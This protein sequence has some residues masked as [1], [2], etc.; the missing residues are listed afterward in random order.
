MSLKA[1]NNKRIAKNT[2]M[3]YIRMGLVMIISLYATRIVLNVLG[4]ED[5]GIYNVVGGV[6]VMFSFLSRTLASA[7]QRYFAFEIGRGDYD[8]LNK[9]FNINLIL[10]A[11]VIGIVLIL[12]E[13]VGL[14]FVN[15]QMTIPDERMFAARWVYQFA[16]L[17][18]CAHLIAIP[19]Q[20]TIIA[21][22]RMDVYAFVG[23]LEA[24]LNLGFVFLLQ[25]LKA[26]Q[27]ALILYGALMLLVHIITNGSYVVVAKKKYEETRTKLY[28]ESQLVKEIISYSGWNLF[29]AV[30]AITRSQG[31]NL[32]I[33]V[34]F[35]PAINAARGLSYQVNNALNQFA[36]N[37]YTAVK[38]QVT[39]YYAQGDKSS[40][41]SL[42]FSSSKFAY[43]LLLFL[44]V[45]VLIYPYEVLE[46]WLVNVPQYAPLFLVLVVIIGLIDS[47]SNPLMTLAQATGKVKIYQAVVGSIIILNLPVSWL[48]LAL[49]FPA[50]A[51][52]YVAI[53]I[54]VIALFARLIIL[55]R[56][57]AFPIMVFCKNVLLRLIITTLA[58]FALSILLKLFVSNTGSGVV[59][60][61]FNI[62]LSV[63]LTVLSILFVG[64]NSH[65]RQLIV[66]FV[67]SRQKK[68]IENTEI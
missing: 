66:G 63:L 50:E 1:E 8:K 25:A 36:S 11:I 38:P 52:M 48:F 23:I 12:A 68:S 15:T 55:N 64:L 44:A 29:G 47:I 20:A 31:I 3:L 5:Y 30:A 42:V 32:L 46:V 61:L 39:K 62:V 65:E 58:A 9:I 19:Y 2:F 54:A 56:I 34:F 43:Y 28:W 27:D 53:V 35:S 6:V 49:G 45:P 21:R 24:L 10:F 26:N 41:F 33:N 60:L 16:V 57:V 51:T 4:E 59:W 40:A 14:W 18:F 22:E 37:F 13:T 17:S 67:K 7:S